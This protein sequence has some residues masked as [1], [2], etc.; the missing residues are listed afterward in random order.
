MPNTSRLLFGRKLEKHSSCLEAFPSEETPFPPTEDSCPPV[1][2]PG[3]QC[4]LPCPSGLPSGGLSADRPAAQPRP[5]GRGRW[6]FGR[7]LLLCSHLSQAFPVCWAI[8]QSLSSTTTGVGHPIYRG[9][10]ARGAERRGLSPGQQTHC[11]VV[12]LSIEECVSATLM[13]DFKHLTH[14]PNGRA[15]LSWSAL[16]ICV[17]SKVQVML[18]A[19]APAPGPWKGWDVWDGAPVGVG[20]KAAFLLASPLEGIDLLWHLLCADENLEEQSQEEAGEMHLQAPWVPGQLEDLLQ[21]P[22]CLQKTKHPETV[23]SAP[24]QGR[25]VGG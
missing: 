1:S 22:G 20:G 10:M 12:G 15:V 4:T 13:I 2:A 21:C 24:W 16:Q 5:H 19:L 18:E 25:S 17:Q 3:S 23:P 11:T 6:W 7:W 9:G 14:T 8:P